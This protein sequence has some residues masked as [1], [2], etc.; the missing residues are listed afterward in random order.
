MVDALDE[1]AS[2]LRRFS[3]GR[4]MIVDRWTFRP[5]SLQGVAAFKLPQLRRAFTF[6]TDAFV[7]RFRRCG[8]AGLAPKP[9]WETG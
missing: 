8:L 7:E 9:V 1:G 4:I 6:V 2:E 3:S 5:E